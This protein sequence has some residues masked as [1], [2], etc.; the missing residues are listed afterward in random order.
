MIQLTQH[1][2]NAAQNNPDVL[3]ALANYH[4]IQLTMADAIGDYKECVS[5]HEKRKAELLAAADRIELEWDTE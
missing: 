1:E 2:I 3:R 5:F 4:E